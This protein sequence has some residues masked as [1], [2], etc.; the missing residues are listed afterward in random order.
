NDLPSM[1]DEIDSYILVN[2]WP[3]GWYPHYLKHGFAASDPVL[4]RL[5]QVTSPFAWSEA[6][7]DPEREPRAAR[8]MNEARDFGLRDGLAVPIY[9]VHGF[10]A[11][12]SYGAERFE[13]T[14]EDRAALQLISIYAH[15]RAREIILPGDAAR[16]A[17]TPKLS[18]REIECLKWSSVGKSHGDIGIILSLSERTIEAYLAAAARKLGAVNRT[19]AVAE[20]LRRNLIS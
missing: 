4:R 1:G 11:V 12:A 7:Y 3:G 8:V 14:M 10:H 20:A 9:T 13:L 2:G 17:R 5:R 19:H 18:R 6:P 16:R 15:L